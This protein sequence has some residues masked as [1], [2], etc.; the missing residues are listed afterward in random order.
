MTTPLNL[1]CSNKPRP[2]VHTGRRAGLRTG[3]SAWGRDVFH[4][5]E[6][7]AGKMY[8]G[9]VGEGWLRLDV[10]Q[11]VEATLADPNFCTR[12]A[13]KLRATT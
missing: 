4:A 3:A 7:G 6:K 9:V 1:F 5:A 13:A 8:C 11:P 12:C 10:S 2:S